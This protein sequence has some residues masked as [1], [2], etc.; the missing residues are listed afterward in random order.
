MPSIGLSKTISTLSNVSTITTI[1]GVEHQ[2][3][4]DENNEENLELPIPP[5]MQEGPI[6]HFAILKLAALDIISSF[7]LTIGFSII[8]SGVCQ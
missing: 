4:Y 7:A 5:F 2:K 8:G 3:P 1:V 6:P